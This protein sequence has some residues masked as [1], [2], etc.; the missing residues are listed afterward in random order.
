MDVERGGSEAEEFLGPKQSSWVWS[1]RNNFSVVGQTVAGITVAHCRAECLGVVRPA[2]DLLSLA[3]RNVARLTALDP[4]GQ[5][6]VNSQQVIC[7]LWRA[8]M[9]HTAGLQL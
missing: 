4:S 2:G 7:Y 9:R 1:T 5:W 8:E 6:Q 3:G